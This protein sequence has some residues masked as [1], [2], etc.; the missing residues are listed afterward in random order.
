MLLGYNFKSP[1]NVA[2]ESEEAKFIEESRAFLTSK[3]LCENLSD[4]WQSCLKFPSDAALPQ[5][6]DQFEVLQRTCRGAVAG[7][8]DDHW[9]REVT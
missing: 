9:L 7:R 3:V 4:D 6:H 5:S 2:C 1:R 8:D